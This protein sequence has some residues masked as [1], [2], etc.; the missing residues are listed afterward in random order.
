MP[1]NHLGQP[2]GEALPDWSCATH[3]SNEVI[4]GQFCRIERLDS[5]HL[6]D[7]YRAFSEDEQ[8]RIWTYMSMG[9]FNQK[10]EFRRWLTAACDSSDPVF[11]AL[12]DRATKRA[13]G[14]CAYM[15]IQPEVG[16]IEIGNITYAPMMQKT[17]MA[18]EAMYL[19]MRQAFDGLGYRRYEWKCDALNAASRQA[20][21]RLGFVYEGLFRQ[22]LVYKQRSRDTAWFSIVDKE[23]PALKAAFVAW[24]DPENFDEEG[25]QLQRLQAFR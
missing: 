2:I 8:G 25:A 7:L 11:Y 23:W 17:V 5:M 3:P 9:P 22:A 20:A 6:E 10:D 1:K 12:I 24:L 4:E 19:M 13:A 14:I 21:A 15:R 18:T 16:V